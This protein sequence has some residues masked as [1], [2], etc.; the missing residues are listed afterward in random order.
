MWW[1]IKNVVI[2]E[3]SYVPFIIDYKCSLRY[4]G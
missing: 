4:I 3:L 1:S 2:S